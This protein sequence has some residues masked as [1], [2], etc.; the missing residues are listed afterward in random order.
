MLYALLTCL[1]FTFTVKG[2]SISFWAGKKRAAAGICIFLLL[3]VLCR[4]II[5]RMA[6]GYKKGFYCLLLIVCGFFSFVSVMGVFYSSGKNNGADIDFG[7]VFGS[8]TSVGKFLIVFAGGVLLFHMLSSALGVLRDI[9]LRRE[10]QWQKGAFKRIDS[11]LMEEKSFLKSCVFIAVF[12]LPQFILRYPGVPVVDTITC[13]SQY[14]GVTGYTTQHPIIYTQLLGRFADFGNKMGNVSAG[15]FLLILIQGAVLLLSFAY[16]LDTM[17]KFDAPRWLRWISLVLFAIAPVYA[18]YATVFLIDI[19]YCAFILILITELVWYLLKPEVYAGS[20]KHPAL[21]AIAVLGM[22]FRHNGIYV[23]LVTA[24]VAAMREAYLLIRKKQKG[25]R[26]ALILAVLLVPLVL[27]KA[28]ESALYKKYEV[29]HT[30]ARAMLAVPLQQIGRYMR[31]NSDD[32]TEE[33]IKDIQ[34]VMTYTPSEYGEN[35]RPYNMDGVKWGFKNDASKED[36]Q[37]F[38]KAWLSL[39][40]K[41]PE[42]FVNATL[43]Q[44]YCLFS[45]LQNNVKYYDSAKEKL[46]KIDAVDFGGMYEQVNSR[47]ILKKVLKVYYRNFS[48]IPLVG[49]YV[50]QGIMDFL[51]LAIC[52]Y[53]LFDKNGK[54][55]LAA[56]PLLLTL[57]ITFVGPAAMGHPRYTFPIIYSMP[58]L[59]GLFLRGK[60]CGTKE[61][62]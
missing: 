1:F 60:G 26:T 40:K 25:K 31:N 62:I 3:C 46:T 48:N 51:L 22:F 14:Y 11:F 4:W 18:G 38:W 47:G 61:K 36:M 59:L 17:K 2:G 42:T 39:L 44:N 55:L 19:F 9:C 12:W 28:N 7:D 50:N 30:S 5:H 41:H 8:V 58:L 24:L 10:V 49:F 16:L 52:I 56:L 27:G 13:L 57:A 23:A 33:E 45:P 6:L 37:K 21:T 43:N 20:W 29:T 54:L 32:L 34:A 15:M 53:S 35:Y